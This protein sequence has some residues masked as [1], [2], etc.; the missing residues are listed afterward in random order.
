M[1]RHTI[2]AVD[3]DSHVLE[4]LRVNCASYGFEVFTARDGIEA[5]RAM[6]SRLPDLVILDV[7]MPEMDGWEVCKHVRDKYGDSVKI[8]MLTAKDTARD[9]IIGKSILKADEYL[10]KPFD[11]DDLLATITRLLSRDDS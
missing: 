7:M 2:L 10:T 4:L 5:I 3:D 8:V 1:I 11:I 6:E 9:K